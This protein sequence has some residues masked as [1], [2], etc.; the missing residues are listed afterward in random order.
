MY[1]PEES[2]L[3]LQKISDESKNF[4]VGASFNVSFKE[5]A[6]TTYSGNKKSMFW[7]S[8]RSLSVSPDGES[9]AYLS[10][11]NKQTNVM[12]RRTT[13]TGVS[14]QRT[15]RDATSC[16]WGVDG[17]LY[18]SNYVGG[19]N[20]QVESVNATS[21]TLM[22]QLTNN[23][24]DNTPIL[25]AD[26]ETLYFV[27]FDN[28]GPSVWMLDIK[29]NTLTSCSRGYMPYPVGNGKEEFVCVRNSSE[30]KSEIWLVNFVSG[31]ETLLV[32][33]KEKGFSNPCVSKDGE[34]IVFEGTAKSSVNKRQNVDIFA[35]KMDG[36]NLIQLTYHPEVDC[37]PV[38]SPDGKAIYFISSRGSRDRAYNI[39][40]MNF[41]Y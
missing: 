36:T 22:R 23:N 25:S 39:W 4:V 41:L 38:W 30:G 35:M 16:F 31:Q 24:H 3:N 9:L 15:F 40:K 13:S 14:T 8:Q 10:V 29:N 37:S 1:V 17:Y 33:D 12:V 11:L 32:T 19:G 26:G 7:S 2:G 18:Y 28:S 21:G 27:R 20:W 34:W 5:F 6:K